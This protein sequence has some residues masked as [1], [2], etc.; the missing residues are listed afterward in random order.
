MQATAVTQTTTATSATSTNKDDRNI[1]TAHNSRNATNSRNES[2][3]STANT[4]WMPPKAGMLA[5][6]VKLATAWREANSSRDN[7]NITGSTPEGRPKTTMTPE[8][9]ETCQQQY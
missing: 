9:V 4:V 3:N 5:K 1:M 8:I 6:T 2:N 7:R